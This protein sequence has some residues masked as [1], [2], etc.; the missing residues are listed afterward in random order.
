M[1]VL[2]ASTVWQVASCEIANYELNDDLKDIA[3][4][5][6]SRRLISSAIERTW[7]LGLQDSRGDCPYVGAAGTSIRGTLLSARTKN[8]RWGTREE[9]RPGLHKSRGYTNICGDAL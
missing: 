2:V 6:R 3:S 8:L 5:S 4:M 7:A 1:F 9:R